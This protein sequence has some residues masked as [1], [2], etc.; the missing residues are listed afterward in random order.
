MTT[1]EIISKETKIKHSSV[2]KLI[3]EHENDLK[4]FGVFRFEI[5]KPEKGSKVGRP[6]KIVYLNEPQTMLLIMFMDNNKIVTRFKIEITKEFY[7]M[8]KRIKYIE[9][10]TNDEEWKQIRQESKASRLE[11]ANEI[12]KF[13]DYAKENGSENSEWYYKSFTNLLYNTLFIVQDDYKDMENKKNYM[14]KN[15]LLV[16]MQ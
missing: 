12:K 9:N 4:E 10:I 7:M 5:R 16:M 1:S 11:E 14:N 15:Q 8:K 3:N 6:N 2:L 13:A